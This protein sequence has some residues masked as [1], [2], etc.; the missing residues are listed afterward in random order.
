MPAYSNTLNNY[1]TEN[2]SVID[3]E[4]LNKMLLSK[5]KVQDRIE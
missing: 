4:T 3:N 2:G 1:I 5:D